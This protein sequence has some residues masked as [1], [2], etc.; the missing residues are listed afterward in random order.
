MT[1]DARERSTDSGEPIRLYEYQ[2]GLTTWR[3]CTGDRDQVTGAKAWVQTQIRDEGIRR[4]SDARSDMLRVTIPESL[5][6]VQL[7]RGFPPAGELK[8]TVY[9]LH[10]GDDEPDV[11]WSGTIYSVRRKG[12]DRYETIGGTLDNSLSVTGLRLCWQ[13]GCIHA[14]YD[15][16]CRVNKEE[17][18][19]TLN[20]NAISGT[21]IQAAEA[22]AEVDG[23]FAGGFV[24]WDP[25][26]GVVDRRFIVSHTDQQLVLLGGTYGLADGM[27]IRGYAGC[28][29]TRAVCISKFN[30]GP[31]YGGFELSGKSPFD[32]QPVF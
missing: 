15:H 13:R 1:F 32:G 28:T 5:P 9:T 22:A 29:R 3:Y 30:N 25:T 12:L 31:N 23:W 14:L 2:R 7:Y 17:F 21:A 8:L 20:I 4:T 19:R 27:I 24:E 26:P 11:I 16:W 6:L 18:R 10:A